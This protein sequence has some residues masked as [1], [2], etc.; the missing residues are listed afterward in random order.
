MSLKKLEVE[1]EICPFC[2]S[3]NIDLFTPTD[4]SEK[5]F[6]QV[7]CKDCEGSFLVVPTQD[8]YFTLKEGKPQ[9]NGGDN[10]S[11]EE[12]IEIIEDLIR[13]KKFKELKK[14]FSI[15]DINKAI[16]WRW[17]KVEEAQ[18]TIEQSLGHLRVAE[19]EYEKIFDIETQI[20]QVNID[21]I[22]KLKEL[23]K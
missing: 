23:L 6:F 22:N 18:K 15:S 3:Q 5:E 2:D 10:I 16:A 11:E 12:K 1:N 8:E 9:P 13:D 7:N 21:E 4:E 19:E 17:G 20:K 14:Q